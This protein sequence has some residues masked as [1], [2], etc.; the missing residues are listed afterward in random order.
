MMVIGYWNILYLKIII[1]NMKLLCLTLFNIRKFNILS[2][3]YIV[4]LFSAVGCS[5]SWLSLTWQYFAGS[6]T[7]VLYF[8]IILTITAP[9]HQF[10][11]FVALYSVSF[12]R[13]YWQK[14][15]LLMLS[16]CTSGPLKARKYNLYNFIY[17]NV[18]LFYLS[19]RTFIFMSMV[20]FIVN[21]DTQLL[22]NF[23]SRWR[24]IFLIYFSATMF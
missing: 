3:C 22:T 17:L 12:L 23:M 1:F 13:L 5:V 10:F 24:Q 19:L 15:S 2:I 21:Y 18:F 14:R 6:W 20:Y 7:V 9:M 4:D 11:T 16:F 8:T